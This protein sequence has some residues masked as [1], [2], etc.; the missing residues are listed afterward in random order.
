MLAQCRSHTPLV[1]C[2]A[3]PCP[4]K[5]LTDMNPTD[6]LVQIQWPALP[7]KVKS[8]SPKK[9]ESLSPRNLKVKPL[10]PSK[11]RPLSP[12]KP[13][14]T[15]SKVLVLKEPAYL[16]TPRRTPPRAVDKENNASAVKVIEK[17][18]MT[19]TKSERGTTTT[20]TITTTTTTISNCNAAS[21]PPRRQPKRSLPEPTF[22]RDVGEDV[23]TAKDE[24]P[25][26]SFAYQ[27]P[28]KRRRRMS[29][30]AANTTL[31]SP[32]R[33]RPEKLNLQIHIL[34]D[35]GCRG[36]PSGVGGAGA[37]VTIHGAWAD[38][39]SSRQASFA[40]R[41]YHVRHYIGDKT[42]SN[43]AEYHACIQG[44]LV[45]KR[46]ASRLRHSVDL[47]SVELIVRGD[48]LLVIEQLRGEYRCKGALLRPLYQKASELMGSFSRL[49]KSKA[50]LEHIYRLN[51][52][53]ADGT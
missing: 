15:P 53:K 43:E 24:D 6:R 52:S 13:I 23:G 50:S 2:R 35:G 36:R 38:D 25:Q 37:C 8:L 42:T 26:D 32:P 10:T 1:A 49:G 29:A 16:S 28:A 41:S 12:H 9:M 14:T 48:S 4:E 18:I 20:T 34:F 21:T 3:N 19:T 39:D 45:A 51:N 46:E 17:T 30:A 27:P 5:A 40:P 31:Q 44:L 11:V 47:L 22:L 7:Q 33:R